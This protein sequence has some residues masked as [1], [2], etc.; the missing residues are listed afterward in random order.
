M[1]ILTTGATGFLGGTLVRNLISN[2]GYNPNEIRVLVMP[3]ENIDDLLELGVKPF[4][5]DL[6][7]PSTLKGIMK[8][9]SVVYHNAALVVNDIFSRE[10]IMRVNREGT[11]VLA[12]EFLKE[13]TTEKFVFA[14][15]FGVYGYA[16]PKYPVAE[17]YPKRP[18]NN[19]QESKLLAEED[20]FRLHLENGLNITAIRNSLILGPRDKVTS[21]RVSQGLL[22]GKISYIGKGTNKLSIVDARDSSNAMILSTKKSISKGKAYNV[23]SYDITQNE[24]FNYYSEACGGCFPQ[25][26]YPYWLA[27]SFAWLKEI[28]TPKDKEVLVSRTRVNRYH[29]TRMLDSTKIQQEL[30][31]KP[32]HS[33]S[34][35]SINDAVSWLKENNYLD[36]SKKQLL[37]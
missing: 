10:E 14:S 31:F 37:T 3:D 27:Y 23:K 5:G 16:F 15:S 12:E 34:R 29:S 11:V 28:S 1:V 17:D 2:E 26:R 30:D 25:K 21:L 19:Y 22:N 33:D 9:V 8:D 35:K 18:I 4:V 13:N 32:I 20:L 7:F 24:Y 6:R 36:L